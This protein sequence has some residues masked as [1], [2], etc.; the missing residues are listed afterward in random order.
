MRIHLVHM[1]SNYYTGIELKRTNDITE[2]KFQNVEQ[3]DVMMA[4][5][6]KINAAGYIFRHD[7]NE[8]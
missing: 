1:E 3:Y 5:H 6:K 8:K 2:V 7:I 4:L